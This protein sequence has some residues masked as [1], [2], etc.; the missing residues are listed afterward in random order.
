VIHTGHDH[1]LDR[2]G[3]GDGLEVLGQFIGAVALFNDL[4]FPEGLDELL[5]EE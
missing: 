4:Q 2:G 3:D 1:I 5:D